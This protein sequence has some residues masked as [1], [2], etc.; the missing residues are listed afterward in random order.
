MDLY[1][2]KN[3]TKR[4]NRDWGGIMEIVSATLHCYFVG[5]GTKCLLLFYSL[6]YIRKLVL[7]L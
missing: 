7:T 1:L 6:G 4:Y 3:D 2:V 5:D